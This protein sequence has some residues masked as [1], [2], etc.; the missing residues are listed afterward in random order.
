MRWAGKNLNSVAGTCNAERPWWPSNL[1]CL[2][3]TSAGL[4]SW[5]SLRP[6]SYQ[7]VGDSYHV[8]VPRGGPI[9]Q[10]HFFSATQLLP[11]FSEPENQ[12]TVL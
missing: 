10:L 5:V 4:L 11:T 7:L 8:P 1:T 9:P 2:T 6:N 12:P 3:S